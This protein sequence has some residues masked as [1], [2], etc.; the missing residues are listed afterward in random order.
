MRD[1]RPNPLDLLIDHLFA[2]RGVG[3]PEFAV[4]A[5]GDSGKGNLLNPL[6]VGLG[7]NRAIIDARVDARLIHRNRAALDVED[8]PARGF[9]HFRALHQLGGALTP[10]TLCEDLKLHRPGQQHAGDDE[11]DE[12][13]NFQTTFEHNRSCQLS[14]IGSEPENQVRN[15]LRDG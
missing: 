4:L 13:E 3:M 1:V 12:Q 8:A 9:D 6:L 5:I 14:A 11:H 2:T 7:S 10:I 15:F